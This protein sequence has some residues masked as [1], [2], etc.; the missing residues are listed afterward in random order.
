MSLKVWG[1]YCYP[2]SPCNSL[3]YLGEH[4]SQSCRHDPD[5]DGFVVMGVSVQWQCYHPHL[6]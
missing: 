4:V 1:M 6:L 2:S 3:Y 5:Q